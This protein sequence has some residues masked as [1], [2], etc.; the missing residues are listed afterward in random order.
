MTGSLIRAQFGAAGLEK[1]TDLAMQ[2][3]I[4]VA[5]DGFTVQIDG[6]TFSPESFERPSVHAEGRS[7]ICASK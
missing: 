5:R 4:N 7:V 1:L 2:S 3:K 6:R